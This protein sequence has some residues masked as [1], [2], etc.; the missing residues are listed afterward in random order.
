MIKNYFKTAFR[1]LQRNKSYAVINI[2]GLTV[3]IAACM[4][5]YLITSYHLSF[6]TFN[7]KKDRI[8]RLVSESAGEDNQVFR[9]PGVP[10]PT[11]G[12][13]GKIIPNWREK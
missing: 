4:I 3:G 2:T 8:Y 10:F 5:I 12:R 7:N 6:D 13:C 9:S 1:S 11:P